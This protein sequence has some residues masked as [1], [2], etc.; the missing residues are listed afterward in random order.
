MKTEVK[1]VIKNTIGIKAYNAKP[2]KQRL[3]IQREIEDNL[4]VKAKQDNSVDIDAINAYMGV[5]KKPSATKTLPAIKSVTK[6][7][8]KT[9]KGLLVRLDETVANWLVPEYIEDEIN[10][11]DTEVIID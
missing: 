5:T 4:A 6:D 1:A 9:G 11:A 2:R 7:G 8:A 10:D 3:Q